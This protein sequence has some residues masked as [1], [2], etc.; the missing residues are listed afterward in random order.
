MLQTVSQ[1]AA[2]GTLLDLK[3]INSFF[4]FLPQSQGHPG[5]L[6]LQGPQGP[7]GRQGDSGIQGHKGQKGDH[8]HGGIM[9]LKGNVVK[10]SSIFLSTC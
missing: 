3:L 7:L 1:C 9:G 10:Y 2:A 4:F 6:G 8:G 5:P